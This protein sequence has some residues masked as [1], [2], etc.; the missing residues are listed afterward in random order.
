MG[1]AA[2][3]FANLAGKA[4]VKSS[5]DNKFHVTGKTTPLQRKLK[6]TGN[7]ITI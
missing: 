1:G 7:I 6:R 4:A 5:T 2:R 3:L